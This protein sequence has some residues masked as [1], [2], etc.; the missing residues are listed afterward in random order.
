MQKVLIIAEAGVNHNGDINIAKRLIDEAKRSGADIVKFQTFNPQK[1]A[2][3]YATMAEYQ[4]DNLGREES[5][6]AMLSKLTLSWGEYVELA[7]YCKKIGIKF[8]STPFESESIHF[9]D[10]LQDIWKI[11]SGEITNYPYLVDIAKTGKEV[12]LSTG[13]SN[14]DE[15]KGAIDVLKKHG[16]GKITLLHCTTNYPTPMDDVNLRAMLTLEKECGCAVGYSDHTQGIEVPIAAVAMGATVIEKHF[17]LDRNMDG[18]DHKASLEPDELKAMVSAIRN[19]EK[20]MG[21]G[22]KVPSPS[23]M[24]NIAVVRKS[25]I[26]A[27]DIRAGEIFSEE[28]LTTKRPGTGI[29]PMR[30][31]EVLGQKAKRDFAE[32]ELIEL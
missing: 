30:W 7:E 13:M 19:V 24:A 9:L 31:N 17:T 12:I 10:D 28:N 11:P 29:N 5:Q 20:A 4:K 3:K 27:K 26:A 25:I 32:D 15:V 6:E 1:L 14:I 23:E 21:D 8:L 18:P 16:A 2:S 22:N